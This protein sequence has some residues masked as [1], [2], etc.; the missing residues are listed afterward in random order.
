MG[1]VG[2]I[3]GFYPD[4]LL[5]K[6]QS[7]K[8]TIPYLKINNS[9][10]VK[11]PSSKEVT[12][13]PGDHLISFR[14]STIGPKRSQD[15]NNQYMI[16]EIHD[17]WI[18]AKRN[19]DIVLALSPGHYKVYYHSG[20]FFDKDA[21][22]NNYFDL[23][24]P[25]FWYQSKW[26]YALGTI[27][28]TGLAFL[29]IYLFFRNNWIKKMLLLESRQNLQSERVRISRDLHDNIGTQL[30]ILSRSLN[31][32]FDN[33]GQLKSDGMKERIQKLMVISKYTNEQLRDVIWASKSD[34]LT[35]SDLEERIK[36]FAFRLNQDAAPKVQVQNHLKNNIGLSPSLSLNLFRIVQEGITNSIKHSQCSH[37]LIAFS[38]DSEHWEVSIK[39]DGKGFDEDEI[40]YGEGLSNMMQRSNNLG[41]DIQIKSIVD[42][43]TIIICK[44]KKP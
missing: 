44:I 23:I 18:D 27:F 22:K 20:S 31:W 24:V 36:M 14:I 2:G 6:Y 1:G 11:M 28:L 7:Y 16:P 38:E 8:Y 3:V 25:A 13:D 33:I 9:R 35:T 41:F 19:R 30:G 21:P 37:I 34:H 10:E 39:D 42:V 32:I 26:F 12:L 5:I 4:S 15:Y 29:A 40:T 17:G 43:G